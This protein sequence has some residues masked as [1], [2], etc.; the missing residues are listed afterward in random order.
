LEREK[1]KKTIAKVES[2]TFSIVTL[3]ITTEDPLAPLI[4]IRQQNMPYECL[5]IELIN[6]FYRKFEV[7]IS[8][9]VSL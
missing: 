4:F 5:H 2:Y 8:N 6:G 9:H 3:T 7:E 1:K